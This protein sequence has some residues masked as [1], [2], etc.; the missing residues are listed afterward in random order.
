MLPMSY[1]SVSEYGRYFGNFGSR[2]PRQ[3]AKTVMYCTAVWNT[4]T[5]SSLFLY[6]VCVRLHY[7][8]MALPTFR[9]T[10]PILSH[11]ISPDKNPHSLNPI[12][13]SASQD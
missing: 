10:H 7:I 11:D 12:L 5:Q 2:N 1:W 9:G 13:E 3:P 8:L 4:A 6:L